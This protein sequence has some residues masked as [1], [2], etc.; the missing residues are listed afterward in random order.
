MRCSRSQPCH[1]C[2]R[3]SRECRYFSYPDRR[4]SPGAYRENDDYDRFSKQKDRDDC[5]T[6]LE[7]S[8]GEQEEQLSALQIMSKKDDFAFVQYK[9]YDSLRN[10][11]VRELQ[12][13]TEL[14]IGRLSLTQC[15]D[16]LKCPQLA[17][18]VSLHPF[19]F[20]A[21]QACLTSQLSS[22]DGLR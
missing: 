3:F 11:D 10:F 8:Q 1:N 12:S 19:L 20:C 17:S 9:D 2:R 6:Q 13:G 18:K 14:Q 7:R 4:A 15:I 21:V 5:Y 22:V 16:D